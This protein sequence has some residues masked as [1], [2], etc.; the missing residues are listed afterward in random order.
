M[1]RTEGRALLWGGAVGALTS[2][3][4]VYGA[5]VYRTPWR[6]HAVALSAVALLVMLGALALSRRFSDRK[7]GRAAGWVF[8]AVN[9]V[10]FVLLIG[11]FEGAYNHVLK[12]VLWLS[13]LPLSELRILFP[14]PTYELPNDVF[15]ELTG[16]AQPV[17]ALLAARSLGALLAER[18]GRDVSRRAPPA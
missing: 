15:F 6:L 12:N 14:P 2:V 18:R 3:H 5:I 7:L 16:V 11:C 10:V 8:W 17:P 9:A 4:H 13:G 1:R